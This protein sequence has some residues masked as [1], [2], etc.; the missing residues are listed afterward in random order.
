[1]STN[2][3]TLT[4]IKSVAKRLARAQ[5]LKHIVAL[6]LVAREL[7][8]PHWRGLAEAYKLGWRPAPEQLD[9][10]ESLLV[11]NN[12]VAGSV[13]GASSQIQTLSALGDGLIFTRWVPEGVSPMEADEIH[14]ELDGHP[15]YLVGDEFSV[16][17]GSQGWEIILDQPPLAKPEV[18]RLGGHVKSVAALDPAFVE[19]ATV[20][21]KIRAQRMHSE[22]ASDWPRRSTMPDREGRALHPLGRGLSAEWHCLHCDGVHDGRT[23]ARN[24]WHC[25]SC[26]GTP[27]DIFPTP[28]WNEPRQSVKPSRKE[29]EV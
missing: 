28:F 21:V 10:L 15:F 17:I 7:G 16:A 1:M 12:K 29:A 24:L 20:L 5:R 19:R 25:P 13:T 6:E 18:R 26:N 4:I 9:G 27:I 22:V 11:E 3:N 8:Q 2:T 14:G 23:M